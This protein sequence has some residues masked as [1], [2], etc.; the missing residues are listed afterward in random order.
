MRIFG[1]GAKKALVS[2]ALIISALFCLCACSY[3]SGSATTG[4]YVDFLALELSELEQY[5]TLGAYKG[6]DVSLDG[7][8]K[9]NAVW[10]EI[11]K[12]ASV[13]IYPNEQVYYYVEQQR[14]EYRY[15][16]QKAGITYEAML[17]KL[18]LNEGDILREAKELTKSDIIYAMIVKKESISLTDRDRSELFDRYV[19]KYVSEYG[20]TE[21]YVGTNLADE[22]YGSMLYD[23][24]TEF[25]IINNKFS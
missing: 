5:V 11:A 17:E 2:V 1:S 20:Y 24:T 7:R 22:I 6:L 15:H 13:K 25:L 9:G 21:E 10:E 16:A 4:E 19:E 14:A 18:A 23:K 8:S 12:G 3:G